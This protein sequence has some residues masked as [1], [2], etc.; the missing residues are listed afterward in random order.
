MSDI[1]LPCFSF[2]KVNLE[3]TSEY[4]DIH[5]LIRFLK[6]SECRNGQR[7]NW[8]YTEQTL[9]FIILY[10]THFIY[11]NNFLLAPFNCLLSFNVLASRFAW[12]A[13]FLGVKF[14][15]DTFPAFVVSSRQFPLNYLV[16]ATRFPTLNM[17]EKFSRLFA[18]ISE[19]TR[20]WFAYL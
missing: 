17:S 5:K 20:W 3:L 12:A 19:S 4:W 13:K 7:W 1:V 2:L 10:K 18:V 14:F 8:T 11:F 6:V 9:Q 16:P 15:S